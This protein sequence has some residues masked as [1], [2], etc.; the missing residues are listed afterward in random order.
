MFSNKF[1]LAELI[2]SL[3]YIYIRKLTEQSNMV[4]LI[5]YNISLLVVDLKSLLYL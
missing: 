4:I 5:E 2:C 3:I 1:D